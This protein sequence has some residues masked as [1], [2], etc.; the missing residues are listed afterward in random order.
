MNRGY[1]RARYLDLIAE[2]VETVPGIALSTDLIVGFPGETD[3]DFEAIK[4]EAAAI[5]YPLM[6]KA[7]W[8]GGGRFDYGYFTDAVLETYVAQA[9]G[10][11][12]LNLGAR[13]APAGARTR[14]G[15]KAPPDAGTSG[16]ARQRT[17]K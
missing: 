12:L 3:A 9:V 17:T 15:A 1:T 8:G 7:S 5:G 14:T 10:Q 2:L 16:S 4:K 11:A 6:L 13:D